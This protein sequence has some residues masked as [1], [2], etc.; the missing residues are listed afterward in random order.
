[1]IYFPSFDGDK[2]DTVV[3][4]K[5]DH[6]WTLGLANYRGSPMTTGSYCNPDCFFKTEVYN[7]ETKQW[8]DASDYPFRS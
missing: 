6:D 3:A 1:M 8:I 4:S 2:F 5:C 7:S